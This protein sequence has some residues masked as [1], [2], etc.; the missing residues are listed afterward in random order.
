MLASVKNKHWTCRSLLILYKLR[1]FHVTSFLKGSESLVEEIDYYRRREAPDEIRTEKKLYE[2]P[3]YPEHYKTIKRQKTNF[4]DVKIVKI[5]SG[6]GGNGKVSFLTEAGRP[7][8]PPDGGDGG[9]GGSVY[10]QAVEGMTSLVGVKS[11]YRAEDGNSGGSTQLSGRNGDNILIQVP[12]GTLIK[13]I[14]DPITIKGLSL[15]RKLKLENDPLLIPSQVSLTCEVDAVAMLYGIHGYGIMLN[16]DSYEDG[17]GWLFKKYEE[18]V[19]R[20]R[21]YFQELN[22]KV[23]FF[24]L[25]TRRR[26][27]DEDLIAMDGIDLVEPGKPKLLMRG[28][29]GGMGN[30]HFL[31]QRVKIPLF[32]KMGRG[33]LES[34]FMFELKLLA[35]L[36]LVGLPNAGKSTLLRAISRARPQVGHWEFTTLVPSIGTIS[37]GISKPSFTVADI[38]GIIKGSK[39]DKGMGLQFLKHVERSGG[40]VFVIALDKQDPTEALDILINEM[41][42]ERMKN[43]RV[44]VV[45]TKADVEDSYERYQRLLSMVQSK[46]WDI[47][48]CSAMNSENIEAVIGMMGKVAGKE[49]F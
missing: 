19:F 21:D 14:P 36:G 30:M 12:I 20:N 48:P 11:H 13:W 7:H 31:S 29:H 10:V 27:Q 25:I 3:F 15:E 28:G 6:R 18:Q 24:D 5:K 38:P 40:L 2:I 42:P 1:S 35:D 49:N 16:R 4:Q 45:A 8:G 23:K 46:K 32:A 37:Q 34:Y 47:V 9:Q 17:E 33:C 43:K 22:D 39:Q 26:E 41:G 44:L